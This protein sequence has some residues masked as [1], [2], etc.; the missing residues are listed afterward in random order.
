VFTGRYRTSYEAY[1]GLLEWAESQGLTA[2]LKITK[3]VYI[4]VNG[5]DKNDG[6]T[7]ETPVRS[8]ARLE[9]LKEEGDKVHFMEQGAFDQM[10][11][12]IV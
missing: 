3:A 10:L 1:L 7:P 2:V 4:S 5:D 11:A 6:L 12:G 9:M 8:I